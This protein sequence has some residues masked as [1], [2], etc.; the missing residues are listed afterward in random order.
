M[1]VHRAWGCLLLETLKNKLWWLS[2]MELSSEMRL[3][4]ERRRSTDLRYICFK[5]LSINSSCLTLLLPKL[6]EW[7]FLFSLTEPS[8]VHVPHRQWTCCWCHSNWRAS[9]VLWDFTDYLFSCLISFQPHRENAGSLKSRMYSNFA[10]AS[11]LLQFPKVITNQESACVWVAYLWTFIYLMLHS[12]CFL[13]LLA[14]VFFYLL[15]ITTFWFYVLAQLSQK[16]N[17]IH[18]LL[19]L[20]FIGDYHTLLATIEFPTIMSLSEHINLTLKL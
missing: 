20:H 3:P 17:I 19:L 6:T 9:K 10:S 5:Y 12:A 13:L 1:C 16:K 4:S 18:T 7:Y 2:T 11:T 15:K 14:A 8:S